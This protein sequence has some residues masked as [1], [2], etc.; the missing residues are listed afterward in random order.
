MEIA[1]LISHFNLA[2]CTNRVIKIESLC[3]LWSDFAIQTVPL[4]FESSSL[5][6]CFFYFFLETSDFVQMAVKIHFHF[7][8][9]A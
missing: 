9:I 1:K 8:I 3:T 7:A 4:F 5:F 6:K 2:L